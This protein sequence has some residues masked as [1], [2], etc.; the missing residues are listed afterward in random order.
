MNRRRVEAVGQL[1]GRVGRSAP[2]ACGF[3]RHA[4]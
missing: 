2:G 3:C 1:E 4:E